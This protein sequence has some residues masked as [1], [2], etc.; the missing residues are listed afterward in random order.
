M[1]EAAADL[2]QNKASSIKVK[3]GRVKKKGTQVHKKAGSPMEHVLYT[4]F[5]Y[6]NN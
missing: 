4:L 6:M 5:L 1:K 3:S 2:P